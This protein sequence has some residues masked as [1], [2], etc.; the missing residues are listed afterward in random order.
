MP[1][2]ETGAQ[3]LLERV[4]GRGAAVEEGGDRGG[5]E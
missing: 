3:E 1:F 2:Q 5:E 4:R